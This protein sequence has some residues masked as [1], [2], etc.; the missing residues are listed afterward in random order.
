MRLERKEIT[1]KIVLKLQEKRKALYNAF[2]EQ[3]KGV[4]FFYIDDLL[5]AAWCKQI[6]DAFPKDSEMMLKKSIRED[7]YVGVQI[8]QYK[9]LIGAAIYAFQH[10]SVIE[11]IK[12]ICNIAECTADASLYAGGI[13][14]MKQK[15]FL[16]PHLDNSHNHNRKKWRVLNLLYY[17]TPNWKKEYGGNLEVWP[18]GLKGSPVTITSK[19]NRLVVMA[20]DKYSWHSV[21]PI[22]VNNRRNCV[23]NYYFSNSPLNK[24]DSF[25][26]TLFRGWPTQKIE[27]IILRMD[28][29]ARMLLRKVFPKGL[30]KN[31]H[32][33]NKKPPKKS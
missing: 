22:R 21:S 15:Q 16:K 7:K 2:N 25:H 8:D 32:I 6:N 17:T 9:K 29:Y 26:V 13:S 12:E 30:V 20:T 11:I 33:Y 4:R 14:S 19:F 5:P 23:S 3:N 24:E 31:P 18:K 28:G 1:A 10:K 27:D